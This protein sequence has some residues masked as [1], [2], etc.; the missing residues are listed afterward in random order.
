MLG[1][2]P[3]VSEACAV[4]FLLVIVEAVLP[5]YEDTSTIVIIEASIPEC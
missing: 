3:H 1:V 2:R 5:A 4:S